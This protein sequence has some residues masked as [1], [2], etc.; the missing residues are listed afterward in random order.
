MPNRK[1]ATI[2]LLMA[3]LICLC[4]ISNVCL[5]VQSSVKVMPKIGTV[6]NLLALSSAS[7]Y[8]ISGYRK[9]AHVYYKG[10]LSFY[11]I[12]IL[13]GAYGMVVDFK[14]SPM[15]AAWVLAFVITY[16]NVMML[17]IPDDLGEKKSKAI[18]AL[19]AVIWLGFLIH[20][21]IF[22]SNTIG[23]YTIRIASYLLSAIL[24]A[25]LVYA[26]YEDKKERKPSN[27]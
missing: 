16:A 8:C 21:F 5:L 10:F 2:G 1:K 4:V 7:I 24:T 14:G 19:N 23:F 27:T 22:K 20:H 18:A 9:N 15:A 13:T 11:A 17:F 12:H 3:V 25:V 26:K 6:L